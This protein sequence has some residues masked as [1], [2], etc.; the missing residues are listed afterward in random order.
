MLLRR[1]LLG[2]SGDTLI[3]NTSGFN[4]ATFPL[5]G[6][7]SD[8]LRIVERFTRQDFGHLDIRYTID[9]RKVYTKPWSITQHL[10]LTPDTELL[11]YFCND[12]EKDL[13]RMRP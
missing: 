8:A 13:H 10:H 7:H 3:V 4:G 5:G 11:E 6:P 1:P 12:N 9:D 2:R